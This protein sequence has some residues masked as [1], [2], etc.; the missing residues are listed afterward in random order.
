MLT[1]STETSGKIDLFSKIIKEYIWP[2]DKEEVKIFIP[3]AFLLACLLFNFGTLRSIKD[4]I[5]VPELG[6]EVISFIKLWFVLPAAILFTVIYFKLS[7]KFDIDKLFI[8]IVSFFLVIVFFFG[9]LIFPNQD[10]FHFKKEKIDFLCQIYPN[11]YW[12]IKI[13]GKWSYT[14][15]YIFAELWGV[16]VIQLMYWQFANHFFKTDQAKR[17]YPILNLMGNIGLI[18]AGFILVYSGNINWIKMF[19]FLGIIGT[20]DLSAENSIK[21]LS[22]FVIIAGILAMIFFKISFRNLTSYSAINEK[23]ILPKK[24]QT[25]LSLKESILLVIRS[26]YIGYLVIMIM[27]YSLAVNLIDGPWKAKVGE[28]YPTTSEY[29]NFSGNFNIALGIFGVFAAI[30]V[31]NLVRKAS[32]RSSAMTVPLIIGVTGTILFLFIII[33]DIYGNKTIWG[34]SLLSAAI[35]IG[36]IQSI[37]SKSTKYSLFD[38]TKELAYIPLSLEL[39]TKGKAA[40]DIIGAKFGKSIGAILQSVAFTIVPGS[41]FESFYIS[42]AIIFVIVIIIWIYSVYKLSIEYNLITK[43]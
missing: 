9:Y 39:R 29:L 7:N 28:L 5:I 25:K 6:A 22:I 21:L 11:F 23:I 43:E 10:S 24:S 4:S 40:A 12:Y 32:W 41:S 36:S 26:K 19:S 37:L 42:L 1:I 38:S 16:I 8:I 13:L 31:S 35:V 17:L 2:I 3:M 34:Y 15:I 27:S 33:S 30:F 20:S 14:I 18:F